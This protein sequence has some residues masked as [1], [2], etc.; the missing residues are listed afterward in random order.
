MKSMSQRHLL[1]TVLCWLCFLSAPVQA[2]IANALNARALLGAADVVCYGRVLAVQPHP[3]DPDTHFHP[4]LATAGAVATV[5]VLSVIKGKVPSQIKVVFRKPA[6][7]V[8]YTQLVPEETTILFLKAGPEA[9]YLV[10]DHNGKLPV[11]LHKPLAYSSASPVDRM[12]AELI[13]AANTDKGLM[14]LVCIEGLADFPLPRVVSYLS[15]LTSL[16]DLAVQGVAY[17]ALI[18]LD[19]PPPSTRL[20]AFFKRHDDTRTWQRY[21]TNAYSNGQLKA[22]ILLELENHFNVIDQELDSDNT[23]PIAVAR[24]QAAQAAVQRWKA[25]DLISFLKVAIVNTT[26]AQ[27]NDGTDVVSYRS[28]AEIIREQIDA[29]G[30]PA[31]LSHRFRKGSRT[32]VSS[33]LNNG[34]LEV[35]EAAA[36]AIDNMIVEAHAFPYPQGGSHDTVRYVNAVREWIKQH[37]QWIQHD[38]QA[39]KRNR[40]THG[41]GRA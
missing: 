13:C 18:R 7:M 10:D 25:F 16:P 38:E 35:S 9:F 26:P 28:I 23:S 31:Y 32:L 41:Q 6:P 12:V 40:Q 2:Y 30:H 1:L 22:R 39:V 33:L 27:D 29:N 36:R 34:N 17:A 4:P 20:M 14:R 11:P 8:D 37:P 19:H 21:A 15:S 24:K 5:N 3:I